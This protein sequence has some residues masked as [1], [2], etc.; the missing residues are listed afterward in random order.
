[1]PPVPRVHW[2]PPLEHLLPLWDVKSPA[3]ANKIGNLRVGISDIHH[4]DYEHYGR[5]N[6][7]DE[8]PLTGR[9]RRREKVFKHCL[10]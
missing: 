7:V 2:V 8:K 4:F 10:N 9:M 5:K 6:D 3:L 1:M